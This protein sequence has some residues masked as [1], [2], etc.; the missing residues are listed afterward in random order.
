MSENRLAFES[1]EKLKTFAAL[2]IH[3]S[4]PQEM[5]ANKI[6]LTTGLAYNQAEILGKVLH[7]IIQAVNPQEYITPYMVVMGV[8]I[9]ESVQEFI[10]PSIPLILPVI[11]ENNEEKKE[12]SKEEIATYI[13][14]VFDQVATPEEKKMAESVLRNFLKYEEA[15]K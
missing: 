7:G 10:P 15:K 9:Q 1:T 11:Q 5:L 13:R 4:I 6:F 3:N 8:A 12:K 14:Y 2:S